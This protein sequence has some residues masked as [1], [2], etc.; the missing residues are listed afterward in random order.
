MNKYAN[1][2][3]FMPLKW[4]RMKWLQ[5]AAAAAVLALAASTFADDYVDQW[6]PAVG[7]MLPGINAADHSGTVQNLASLTGNQGLLLFLN[8]SADW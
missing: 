1:R 8:R 2:E 5:T 6:G 3:R 7:T 4:I